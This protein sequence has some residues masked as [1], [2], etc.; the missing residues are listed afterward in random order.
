[1]E[2][3]ADLSAESEQAEVADVT[4]S[5]SEIVIEAPAAAAPVEF[6]HPIISPA[7]EQVQ[8]EAPV[9]IVT[10]VAPVEERV[11]HVPV[12]VAEE[13]TK[14]FVTLGKWA[15]PDEP[16]EESGFQFGTFGLP[17]PSAAVQQ[18]P[19]Q[20][21][22]RTNRNQKSPGNKNASWKSGGDGGKRQSGGSNNANVAND[23]QRNSA[24]APSWDS[25]TNDPVI[26][27]SASDFNNPAS[28][29]VNGNKGSAGP[30][31]L[32]SS[33]GMESNKHQRGHRKSSGDSEQHNSGGKGQQQQQNAP[34][35]MNQ[36][37]SAGASNG[38]G[39]IMPG[40]MVPNMPYGTVPYDVG[41]GHQAPSLHHNA[42]QFLQPNYTG[43]AAALG[44]TPVTSTPTVPVS[45]SSPT[46]GPAQSG[47]PAVTAG[48]AAAQHQGGYQNVPP[49]MPGYMPYSYNQPYYGH[50]F[51]YGA[52]PQGYYN[53]RGQPMYQQPP[54]NMYGGD[55][56]GGSGAP[57]GYP[58]MYGSQTG[59]F[60]DS[61][62][63]GNTHHHAQGGGN[64][65]GNSERGNKQKNS[66]SAN[67]SAA[68]PQQAGAG[69]TDAHPHTG[70]YPGYGNSY[71]GRGDG[72]GGQQAQYPYQQGGWTP[73]PMMYQQQQSSPSG[74]GGFQGSGGRGGQHD[75]SSKSLNGPGYSGSA[76]SQYVAGN[77]R[78]SGSNAGVSS[79]GASSQPASTAPVSNLQAGGW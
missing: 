51:Y 48:G 46:Q 61:Q 45:G 28:T 52:Q 50:Q 16:A 14:K 67:S 3:A 25:P 26:V 44:S 75:N 69:A 1:M 53:N 60:G 35:G 43:A 13:P 12:V 10:I 41:G 64:S 4:V 30:P 57:G 29:F 76:G 77:N 19:A 33:Q 21:P 55:G 23:S 36:R 31:G 49:G 34:P 8:E 40:G 18:E 66:S 38:F 78:G 56:Y 9:P 63:A 62:Y 74:G 32:S 17:S 11:E 58:D 24:P 72:G 37:S 5:V 2:K 42:G 71:P 47:A 73:A 59:Q 68:L 6:E 70:G 65:G 20:V 39:G 54:R 79:G 22:V 15:T 7:V 27:S